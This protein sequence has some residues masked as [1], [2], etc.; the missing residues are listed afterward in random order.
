[1]KV[2]IKFKKK[3]NKVRI[4]DI[5]KGF[6]NVN[7]TAVTVWTIYFLLQ[8]LREMGID[9]EGLIDDI[10]ETFYGESAEE[11]AKEITRLVKSMRKRGMLDDFREPED[12]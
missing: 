9:M 4:I 1:M 8:E 7:D 3:R 2:E 12:E 5:R 6:C 10:T 11:S